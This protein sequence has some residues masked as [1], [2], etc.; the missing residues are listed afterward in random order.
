MQVCICLCR[1]GINLCLPPAGKSRKAKSRL[2]SSTAFARVSSVAPHRPPW[3][4]TSACCM[5]RSSMLTAGQVS[6]PQALKESSAQLGPAVSWWRAGVWE[7]GSN[8]PDRRGGRHQLRCRQH[9]RAE[10]GEMVGCPPE[11][12]LGRRWGSSRMR[13]LSRVEI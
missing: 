3:T 11:S 9:H 1:H 12:H 7:R 5:G 10:D 2:V 4:C 8:Q 13:K 6:R